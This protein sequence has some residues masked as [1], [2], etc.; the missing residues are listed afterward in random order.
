MSQETKTA[1]ELGMKLEKPII[2]TYMTQHPS[3]SVNY[4][5]ISVHPSLDYLV[6]SP[7]AIFTIAGVNVLVEVKTSKNFTTV[8]KLAAKHKPQIQMNLLVTGCQYALLLFFQTNQNNKVSA[9]TVIEV[10][11]TRDVKWQEKFLKNADQVYLTYLQW[12]HA[13]PIMLKSENKR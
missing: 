9:E 10:K 6:C 3:I 2:A 4:P 12:Y 13:T 7:D 8:Q 5:G 1:M 11:I